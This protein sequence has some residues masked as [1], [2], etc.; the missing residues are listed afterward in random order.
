MGIFSGIK[1]ITKSVF[2]GVK[3]VF[4]TVGKAVKKVAKSIGG[5]IKGAMKGD[6]MSLLMVAGAIYMGGAML[7]AWQSPFAGI[8]GMLAPA[9]SQAGQIAQY[10]AATGTTATGAGSQAAMLAAQTAEFGG[11]GLASTAASGAYGGVSSGLLAAQAAGIDTLAAAADPSL[12]APASGDIN[13][14]M[15]AQSGGPV[16]VVGGSDLVAQ[17]RPAHWGS[18]SQPAPAGADSASWGIDQR[19]PGSEIQGSEYGWN[20]DAAN[21]SMGPPEQGLL[22]K[23]WSG[24]KEFGADIAADPMGAAWEG[25]KGVGNFIKD[26]QMVSYGLL[27]GLFSPDPADTARADHEAELDN[28]KAKRD[29]AYRGGMVPTVTPSGRPLRQGSTGNLHARPR[30]DTS[31]GMSP[32][33][34]AQ[35]QALGMTPLQ[36]AYLKR[37]GKI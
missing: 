32:Q 23:A 7:G 17:G 19:I 3:K 33:D 21:Y 27:T 35:A 1:K 31:G 30:W 22:D 14:A 4:K 10:A 16:D 26:N 29:Y 11:A 18:P 8:N 25:A 36:Y 20:P 28:W 34:A 24:V 5:I 2:K 6:L 12:L 9:G 13:A 15:A 37:T